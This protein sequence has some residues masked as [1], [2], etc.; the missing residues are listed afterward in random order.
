MTAY[1]RVFA[2][3]FPPPAA[4]S[5]PTPTA[6]PV[7]GSSAFGESFGSVTDTGGATAQQFRW[8]RAWHVATLFLLLPEEPITLAVATQDEEALKAKWI[9]QYTPEARSAITYV[10]SED[11]GKHQ[12]FTQHG[13]DDLIRWYKEE[14]IVRH[15]LEHVK[16]GLERVPL[17]GNSYKECSNI[18][19]DTSTRPELAGIIQHPPRPPRSSSDLSTPCQSLSYPTAAQIR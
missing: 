12:P 5:V 18:R 8:D 17:T 10:V 1:D 14:V 9:K 13:K 15:Y 7:L 16:S 2:A 4:I 11:S 19:S 6:T 3:V